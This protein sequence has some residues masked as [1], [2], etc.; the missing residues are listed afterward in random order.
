MIGVYSALN[1]YE[2]DEAFVSSTWFCIQ[3][4][5]TLNGVALGEGVPGSV[6]AALTEA[7]SDLVGLDFVAQATTNLSGA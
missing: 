1:V 6:T 4:V 7:W 3:P 5:A 2:S